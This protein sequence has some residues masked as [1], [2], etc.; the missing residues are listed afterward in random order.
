MG[1]GHGPLRLINNA[2]LVI[3]ITAPR[4]MKNMF[5]NTTNT[6][7]IKDNDIINAWNKM[8]WSVDRFTGY[9]KG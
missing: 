2:H 5:H 4:Q 8:P 9:L 6:E 3:A 7:Y 1:I